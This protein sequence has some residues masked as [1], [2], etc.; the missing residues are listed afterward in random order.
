M[1][2]EVIAEELFIEVIGGDEHEGAANSDV[3]EG[4]TDGEVL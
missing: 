2:K 3:N 1:F 4:V